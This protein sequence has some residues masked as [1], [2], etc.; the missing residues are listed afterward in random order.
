MSCAFRIC[1]KSLAKAGRYGVERLPPLGKLASLG[2]KTQNPVEGGMEQPAR[3]PPVFVVGQLL[4]VMLSQKGTS[5]T[6]AIT[7]QESQNGAK[8][9]YARGCD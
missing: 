4:F 1:G 9:F 5:V 8:T 3:N 6:L 7:V 2:K